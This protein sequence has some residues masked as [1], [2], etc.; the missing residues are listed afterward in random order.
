MITCHGEENQMLECS[1]CKRF[2]VFERMSNRLSEGFSNFIWHLNEKGVAGTAEYSLEKFF[3]NSKSVSA[4]GSGGMI[5]ECLN[6][7][8]GELVEVRSEDEILSTLDERGRLKGLRWMTGMDR[9]CGKRVRV[10]KRLEVLLLENSLEY[11]KLKNTVLLEGAMCDG[12][13]FNGC[14]RSCF[15]YWREAWLKRVEE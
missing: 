14:G 13:A 8:P 1:E 4:S 11:R 2:N 10:F 15:F 7:Q 3:G 9:Y 6:L 5:E 12:K